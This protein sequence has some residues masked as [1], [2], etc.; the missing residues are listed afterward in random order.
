MLTD[1]EQSLLRD[2]EAA[3]GLNAKGQAKLAELRGKASTR[4][5]SPA[6]GA[7]ESALQGATLGW[8]DEGQAAL[9][10]AYDATQGKDFGPAYAERQQALQGAYDAYRA[11]R[12][13]ADFAGNLA[14][15][16]ATGGVVGKA[17]G[18]LA[19][20]PAW[21]RYPASGAA[22]G[23]A[24]GAG[25][26]AP[27]ARLEGAGR[28]AAV[29]GVVGS[30]VPLALGAAKMPATAATRAKRALA[31]AIERDAGAGHRA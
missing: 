8:S 2:L 1:A 25:A 10:A 15:G 31:Q 7:L 18:G 30:A 22:A 23:A 17:L 5:L 13:W 11:E 28:G 12:P 26:A 14:G 4:A 6:A 20:V 19:K 9:G 29:G 27:D 16:V 21:L 24:A 3:D